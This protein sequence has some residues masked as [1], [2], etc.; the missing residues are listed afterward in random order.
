MDGLPPKLVQV[1]S[2]SFHRDS[3]AIL[4]LDACFA[5][6]TCH[7]CKFLPQYLVLLCLCRCSFVRRGHVLIGSVV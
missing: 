5:T 6:V 4:I 1:N 3:L 2:P 7:S